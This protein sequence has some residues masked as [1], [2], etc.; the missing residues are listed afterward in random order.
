LG[1]VVDND[2]NEFLEFMTKKK[3]I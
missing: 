1:K 3:K 2:A